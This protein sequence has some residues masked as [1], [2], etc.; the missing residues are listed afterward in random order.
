MA[1]MDGCKHLH[2]GHIWPEVAPG[3]IKNGRAMVGWPP[4]RRSD[5]TEI[6]ASRKSDEI[7]AREAMGEKPAEGAKYYPQRE[8]WVWTKWAGGGMIEYFWPPPYTTEIAVTWQVVEKM[9]ALGFINWVLDRSPDSYDF[10][11]ES[12]GAEI[13]G[14]G[15]TASLAICRAALKVV[16]DSID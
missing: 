2:N 15:A 4:N 9:E 8:G 14:S 7:V 6:D 1:V 5:M 3:S 11:A 13:N 16:R 10:Y 12:S